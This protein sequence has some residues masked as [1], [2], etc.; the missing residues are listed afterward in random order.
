MLEKL[1]LFLKLGGLLDCYSVLI[2]PSK[3]KI[4]V[5]CREEKTGKCRR[6]RNGLYW[7]VE[8]Y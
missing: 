2:V 6:M 1:D 4:Y 8:K 5:L 3:K 7:C